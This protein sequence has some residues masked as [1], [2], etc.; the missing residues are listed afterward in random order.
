MDVR[1]HH[2]TVH[3]MNPSNAY[4]TTRTRHEAI[5]A[6]AVE[7]TYE[8]V[9]F[10]G[11]NALRWRGPH[12]FQRDDADGRNPLGQGPVVR[13]LRPICSHESRSWD[14]TGVWWLYVRP[15]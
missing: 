12:P 6:L 9:T 14:Y 5:H 4:P 8:R 10:G 2:K 3:I 7:E 13:T 15:R 11:L 1:H